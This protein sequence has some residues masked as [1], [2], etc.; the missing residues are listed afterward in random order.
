[1]TTSLKNHCMFIRA[2]LFVYVF[3]MIHRWSVR[4]PLWFTL[5]SGVQE[6]KNSRFRDAPTPH[7]HNTAFVR[8][9][10]NASALPEHTNN[11]YKMLLFHHY[12]TGAMKRVIC[13]IYS[14]WQWS[15][16]YSVLE[17]C[18]YLAKVEMRQ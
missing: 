4:G 1:M 7:H 17:F 2:G 3:E 9:V 18:T 11:E 10:Q 12:I 13:I 16:Y 8:P 6:R 5:T 14:S 15:S